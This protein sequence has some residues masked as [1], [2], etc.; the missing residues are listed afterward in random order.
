MIKNS[1][2][3]ILS[4]V[5]TALFNLVVLILSAR[6]LG[7]EGRGEITYLLFYCGFIQI[8]TGVVGN[9]VMI[10]MLTKLEENSVLVISF[11]WTFF[12]ALIVS[13]FLFYYDEF[14]E[15]RIFLFLGITI[16]QSLFNNLTALF[17]AKIQI[18][19]L[20]FIKISQPLI[21]ILLLVSN[22]GLDAKLFLTFLIISYLPSLVILTKLTFWENYKFNFS[23]LKSS[24]LIFIRL[25]AL[26]QLNYLMQYGCYRYAIW[27]IADKSNLSNVGVFGLWVTLVDALWLIPISIA[28]INQ[29]YMAKNQENKMN[30]NLCFISA[31]ITLILLVIALVIP[32]SVYQLFL[33]KDF[34][35]IKHLLLISSPAI[36]FFTFSITL[37]YYF[38]AKGKIIYNTISSGVGFFVIILLSKLLIG[39][40][41][42]IGAVLTNSISYSLTTVV[43][44]YL[45]K[46]YN[47]QSNNKA[48]VSN[49]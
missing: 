25:G 8:F 43:I 4:S 9:S 39:K 32:L 27:I 14:I 26:N 47:R 18:Q 19:K 36:I 33:G 28:T 10:F 13:P 40:Y 15:S 2:L 41:G 7:A 5:G 37:A 38:S 44:I 35:E 1:I 16:L 20:V 17:S 12:I 49:A 24:F 42:L 46:R 6:I 45:Y 21:L 31:G 22:S 3:H 34:N 11:I 30:M 48:C 23:T 29:T